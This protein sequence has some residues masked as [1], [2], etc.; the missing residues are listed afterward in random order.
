MAPRHSPHERID[1]LVVAATTVFARRGFEKASIAEVTREMGAS[2]GI[3]YSY[4]EDKE[5]LFQ[6]VLT[7]LAQGNNFMPEQFPWRPEHPGGVE[8]LVGEVV[9]RELIVPTLATA[10][11]VPVI[12]DVVTELESILIEHYRSVERNRQLLTVIERASVDMPNL[13]V[14]AI[15]ARAKL[16]GALSEYI[17]L[18]VENKQIL[19]VADASTTARFIVEAVS[20]FA[21][22]RH[23]DA[24]GGSIP[25]NIAEQ[26]VVTIVMRALVSADPTPSKKLTRRQAARTRGRDL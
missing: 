2:H 12:D 25:D 9:E 21:N 1:Q 24:D 19:D 6:L 22:H 17:R 14:V 5:A 7:R 23:R 13:A 4:V 26:T 18:R 20:W 8:Q 11:K 15:A 3:V 10:L 16:L